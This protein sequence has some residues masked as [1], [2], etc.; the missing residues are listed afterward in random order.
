MET[1]VYL[2]LSSFMPRPAEAIFEELDAMDFNPYDDDDLRDHE[3]DAQL[4]NNTFNY[5]PSLYFNP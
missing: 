4:G 5:H 1:L 2:A 3:L